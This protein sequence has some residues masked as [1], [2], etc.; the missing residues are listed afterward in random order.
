MGVI[1][2]QTPDWLY[3]VA[4]DGDQ[5]SS[6]MQ[7]HSYDLHWNPCIIMIQHRLICQASDLSS[8][9]WPLKISEHLKYY[10]WLAVMIVCRS[11]LSRSDLPIV[12]NWSNNT[13]R[14][15]QIMPIHLCLFSMWQ[16]SSTCSHGLRPT[17]LLLRLPLVVLGFN[18]CAC[19]SQPLW[20]W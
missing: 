9:R 12:W 19:C 3:L 8:R 1:S 17:S 7:S 10:A 13:K 16:S 14:L 2:G 18:V 20:Q 15:W 11:T 5:V 6:P 4:S